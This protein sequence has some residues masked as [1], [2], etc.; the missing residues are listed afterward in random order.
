M[1]FIYTYVKNVIGVGLV[2]EPSSAVRDDSCGV[3]VLCRLVNRHIVVDA[4]GTNY[5]RNYDSFGTVDDESTG[6]CHKREVAHEDFRLLDFAGFSV[7]EHYFN[8]EGSCVVCVAFFAFLYGIFRGRIKR[9][10]H[11]VN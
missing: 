6:I 2:L 9:I 11:E 8:S 1:V 4:G 10:T 5:L 3:Y 7:G